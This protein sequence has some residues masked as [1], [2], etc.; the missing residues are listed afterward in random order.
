MSD[1]MQVSDFECGHIGAIQAAS[2][3]GTID[4]LRRWQPE[5]NSLVVDHDVLA[6]FA[7]VPFDRSEPIEAP[8]QRLDAAIRSAARNLEMRHVS[9]RLI[10]FMAVSTYWVTNGH[11]KSGNV[12]VELAA[13]CFILGLP[14]APRMDALCLMARSNTDARVS[15]ALSRMEE[16][17]RVFDSTYAGMI[18]HG[19]LSLNI[20][21]LIIRSIG[22]QGA[23]PDASG[24]L[25]F[26]IARLIDTDI[27]ALSQFLVGLEDNTDVYNTLAR[28]QAVLSWKSKDVQVN[29][30]TQLMCCPRGSVAAFASSLLAHVGDDA[31]GFIASRAW[32]NELQPLDR[33]KVLNQSSKNSTSYQTWLGDL[34]EWARAEQAKLNQA[35]GL[36]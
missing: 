11:P 7:H 23:K 27:N 12:D 34:I 13:E 9:K 17:S 5:L 20:F 28:V 3:D 26:H 36:P 16:A 18:K 21:Q 33:A 15:W 32:F 29:A 35:P 24:L 10:N 4:D 8:R 19:I 1:A 2:L 22:K 6:Q 31:A 14:Y 30:L 25:R